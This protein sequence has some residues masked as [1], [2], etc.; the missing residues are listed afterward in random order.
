MAQVH[1][2]E[3]DWWTRARRSGS[4]RPVK[5]DARLVGWLL[6]VVFVSVSAATVW[7]LVA[8]RQRT[9]AEVDTGNRNLAQ[10]LNTYAEGV[11]TQSSM[12]L[13]GIAE[14][15]EVQGAEPAHLQRLL[16]LVNRQEHLLNQ[17]NELLIVDAQGRWLMSSKGAFPQG[18]QSAD[19]DFFTHHRDDVSSGIFIGP[20]IRSRS[21]GE[22]VITISRRYA[23]SEGQFAGAVV[24]ALGVENFLRL[25]GKID[26]GE[27]GAIALSTPGGQL[28]VRHPFREQDLGRDFSQSP[29]FL[30]HYAGA[31]SGTASFR[32]LLDGTERIYAFLRS[33]RYPLVTTVALGRDEALSSWRRQA[34]LTLAVVLGLFL[35]IALIGWRL[36][37]AMRLRSRAECSLVSAREELLDANRRLEVLATQDQLTGLA[38]RR[39]FDEV[40]EREARRAAREGTPLSLLLIDLDYFKGYNDAYGHVA[41]DA[42]LQA[43]CSALAQAVQRPGDMAARYG[44]EE[45][46]VVLPNTDEAG[47][48]QVAER[49]RARIEGLGLEHRISRFGHVTASIGVATAQGDVAVAAQGTASDTPTGTPPGTAPGT[50][51]AAVNPEAAVALVEAADRALYRA[52]AAGRNCVQR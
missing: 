52:K 3:R 37:A 24:V 1:V 43:V 30:R 13:L 35:A 11:I 50:T 40:L 46:A 38:N 10:T 18:S 48:L 23:D 2:M 45:L 34:L 28:L 42:C 36:T 29:N 14:R 41:G 6:A 31:M 8:A 33:E 7:Q 4:G 17:L 19:R 5:R 12:L 25:F 49:L 32:S 39:R 9:L 15:L 22:W 27:K 47:A 21:T 51:P 26:I 44:G 16:H 20:P